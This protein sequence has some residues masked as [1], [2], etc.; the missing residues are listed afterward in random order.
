[1]AVIA[2]HLIAESGNLAVHRAG[3]PALDR[4]AHDNHRA[5]VFA[6]PVLHRL[7]R[8]YNLVVVVAVVQRHHVPA[9]SRPLVFDAIC[10]VN[11]AYD[12]ADELVVYAGV[13]VR[14]QDSQP[15]ADLLG[16]RR[17]FH[18]LGVPGRHGEFAF[19]GDYLQAVRRAHD[20]PERRLARGG[21]YA[22]AGRPAVDVVG[23][24]GGF[25]V[26]GERAYAAQLRL[27]HERVV[28][29]PAL[30]QQRIERLAPSAEAERVY[31]EHRRSRVGDVAVV[32][33]AR[34]LARERLAHDHPQRVGDGRVVAAGEHEAVGVGVLR[35]AV[36]VPQPAQL[37]PNQM[38]RD[39]VGRIGE[40]PAEVSGLGVVAQQNERHRREK[41]HV[42]DALLVIIRQLHRPRRLPMRQREGVNRRRRA[43]ICLCHV[44]TLRRDCECWDAVRSRAESA[45]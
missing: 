9:V 8:G 36:V 31:R 33:G 28:V 37:R 1:M 14:E 22:D 7:E 45:T 43:S 15:L 11:G 39:G 27:R 38:G 19:D 6:V 30:A 40:R 29:K 4:L 25:G 2:H 24:V 41:A 16:D 32:A 13:V 26:S 44:N 35:A 20:V 34:V 21:G 42:F 12:A 5:V 23:Q 18:L 3:P 17:R 10:V